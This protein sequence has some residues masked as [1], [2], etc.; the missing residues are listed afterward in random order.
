MCLIQSTLPPRD[1]TQPA[2][3]STSGQPHYERLHWI[4]CQAQIPFWLFHSPETFAAKTWWLACP[5]PLLC[6]GSWFIFN[7]EE[8]HIKVIQNHNHKV[9]SVSDFHTKGLHATVEDTQ[10]VHW[11]VHLSKLFFR[12]SL[13]RSWSNSSSSSRVDCMQ[14][15]FV[16][17]NY[18]PVRPFLIQGHFPSVGT[19]PRVYYTS[20]CFCG[21]LLPDLCSIPWCYWW[22]GLKQFSHYH[23]LQH[24]CS[25]IHLA[26]VCRGQGYFI[27]YLFIW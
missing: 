3:G 14:R 18:H 23:Q 25:A 21:S 1:H 2:P 9:N 8:L 19:C 6:A 26:L 11:L 17:W 13:L 16:G 22:L 12:A 5:M 27:D 20:C 15:N 4:G 24:L 10:K 7:P